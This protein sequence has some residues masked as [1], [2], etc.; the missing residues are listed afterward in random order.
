MQQIAV[1]VQ[2]LFAAIL[3]YNHHFRCPHSYMVQKKY[4]TNSNWNICIHTASLGLQNIGNQTVNK[5][6]QN[7]AVWVAIGKLLELH[8]C[9]ST[10]FKTYWYCYGANNTLIRIHVTVYDPTHMHTITV[11]YHE[12]WKTKSRLKERLTECYQEQSLFKQLQLVKWNQKRTC[13][14]CLLE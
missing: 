1:L 9:P 2:N 10:M 3:V 13:R 5:W 7:A 6:L 14:L 8:V 12:C 11:N 4:L